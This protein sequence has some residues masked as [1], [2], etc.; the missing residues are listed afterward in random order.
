MNF[1]CIL[2]ENLFG[3]NCLFV[4]LQALSRS[5][6]KRL[7]AS[8]CPSVCLS[9]RLLSRISVAPTGRISVKFN[10]GDFCEKSVEIPQIWLK[11]IQKCQTIYMKN[12]VRFSVV[13]D[14]YS[15]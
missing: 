10:L 4:N 9:L 14:I 7:L 1:R 12:E 11:I 6:E 3:I 15:P 2:D 8:S 5:Q 13:G